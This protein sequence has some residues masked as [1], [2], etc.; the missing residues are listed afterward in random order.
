MREQE[1]VRARESGGEKGERDLMRSALH[2]RAVRG[3]EERC[4]V[5]VHN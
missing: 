4:Y 3:E 2:E 1:R 5:Q